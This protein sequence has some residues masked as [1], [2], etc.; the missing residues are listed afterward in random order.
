MHRHGA[1]VAAFIAGLALCYAFRRR[2]YRVLAKRG[3]ST[4]ADKS[5]CSLAASV[6][7]RYDLEMCSDGAPATPQAALYR[8][9]SSSIGE[10]RNIIENFG[11]IHEDCTNEKE[12]QVR[13]LQALRVSSPHRL[14]ANR[15]P[16]K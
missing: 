8:V 5:T 16:V 4:P 10:L 3:Q 9:R 1:A 14:L 13:A 2:C 12:L 15:A 11:L 6:P 7:P